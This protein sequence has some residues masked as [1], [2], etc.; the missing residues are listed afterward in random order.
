MCS[1]GFYLD[2]ATELHFY[3]S[4]CK[5][6]SEVKRIFSTNMYI[7]IN[8]TDEY[9]AI[10]HD[11]IIWPFKISKHSSQ[12]KVLDITGSLICHLPYIFITPCAVCTF[13]SLPLCNVI[14]EK[15]A[16]VCN[17]YVRTVETRNI[18]CNSWKFGGV[19]IV[20]ACYHRDVHQQV[21]YS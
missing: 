13:F 8:Y 18:T 20:Q 11:L 12:Q 15:T 5:N 21:I 16:N 6:N 17:R 19:L 1:D 10:I 3:T 7:C 14:S 4:R 9:K 2:G